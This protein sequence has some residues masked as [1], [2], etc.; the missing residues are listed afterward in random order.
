MNFIIVLITSMNYTT[1][2]KKIRKIARRFLVIF[3]SQRDRGSRN[4]DKK[5]KVSM[6]NGYYPINILENIIIKQHMSIHSS[7]KVFK[8]K[9]ID[10]LEPKTP[11]KKNG[12]QWHSK[13]D[14]S[15]RH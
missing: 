7:N 8:F 11:K 6:K 13:Q 9:F 15:F 12:E 2:F 14:A 5:T 3:S 10:G 4:L 1:I